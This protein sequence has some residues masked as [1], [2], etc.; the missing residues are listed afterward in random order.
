ME[1]VLSCQFSVLSTQYPAADTL[2]RSV[3]SCRAVRYSTISP[4]R[5]RVG[6]TENTVG[7]TTKAKK[8]IP[9]SQTTSESS[10]KKRRTDIGRP[11]STACNEKRKRT[12]LNR[13]RNAFYDFAEYLLGLFGLFQ[14]R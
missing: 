13:H 12:C 10:M 3:Y 6:R 7:A 11:L 5:W 1:P 2:L 9:P 14:S 4:I 8:M